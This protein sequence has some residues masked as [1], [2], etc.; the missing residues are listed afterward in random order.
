MNYYWHIFL[1]VLKNCHMALF[2][3]I[4]FAYQTKKSCTC[5]C[6]TIHWWYQIS[7]KNDVDKIGAIFKHLV[8]SFNWKIFYITIIQLVC[9]NT[10]ICPNGICNKMA[11]D[12][13]K[14]GRQAVG[15]LC[16]CSI[17]SSTIITTHAHT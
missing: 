7:N 3:Y 15:I 9:I 16:S 14:I 10:L 12:G 8:F 1:I 11:T 4:T 6:I 17:K 5:T 2:T 13:W